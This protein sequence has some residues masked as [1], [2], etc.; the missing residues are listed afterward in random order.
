MKDAYTVEEV[1]HKKP[2]ADEQAEDVEF[3]LFARRTTDGNA[4]TSHV[5]M[6]IRIK[7]PLRDS[8][9]LGLARSRPRSHYFKDSPSPE[10]RAQ[11]QAVAVTGEQVLAR[12]KQACPIMQYPWQAPITE[13]S[14]QK[15]EQWL[16]G[17]MIPDRKR[18]RKGKKA[19]IATR[20]KHAKA[21][22]QARMAKIAAEDKE[23]AECMKK[24]KKNRDK[25]LRQREKKKAKR[26]AARTEKPDSDQVGNG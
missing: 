7:S 26:A 3:R 2:V 20:K 17:V 14:C 22:E 10:A 9:E 18:T 5:G 24:A 12:A 11:L 25:K 16:K 13:Q 23:L 4:D 6:R 19:R 1:E 8:E 15:V 21:L